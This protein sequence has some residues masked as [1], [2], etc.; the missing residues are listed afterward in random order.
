MKEIKSKKDWFKAL[1]LGFLIGL[2]VIIPGLS[3]ATIAIVFG[4]YAN[5]LYAFGNIFKDFKRCF[6]F[7]LPIV[8]GIAIGF[9]LGFLVVQKLIELFPFI[10]ICLFAGLMIGSFPAV[11]DTIKGVKF[12]PVR[13]V[14][15]ILGIVVPIALGVL[16]IVVSHN[17]N[18]IINVSVIS[19]LL[20]FVIGFFASLT[21]IIPGLSCSA[22]L[23]MIGQYSVIL[24]S[25]N[26]SVLEANPLI[27]MVLFAL[28]LGFIV[29]FIIFSKGV[30]TLLEKKRDSS[31]CAIVGLSLGSI[32]TMFI[33]PEVAEVYRAWS[34]AGQ[35]ARQLAIG[36]PLMAIGFILT[37]LLVRYQRKHDREKKTQEENKN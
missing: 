8:L 29:G 25:I 26:L 37:Y 7:L 6:K 30:H 17:A 3:S 32:I 5:L 27:L 28:A 34:S 15:F 24:A 4:L 10:L 23:M 33:N 13:S 18:G 35:V 16:S 14:L 12:N 9:I 22:M 20:Y 19:V 1:L 21:Q 31:Y 2:A 36:V 11:L